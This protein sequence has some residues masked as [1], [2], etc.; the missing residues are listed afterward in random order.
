MKTERRH[1]LQTN[2]LADAL[3]RATESAKPYAKVAL[4][5]VVAVAVIAVAVWYLNQQAE[6]TRAE[7]WDRYF[8][9]QSSNDPEA[10]QAVA[11]QFRGTSAGHWALLQLADQHLRTGASAL[12]SDRAEA[13]EELRKARQ[14]YDEVINQPGASEVAQQ[15][16]THGLARTLEALNELDL[17]R[18][19]YEQLASRWPDGPYREEAQRRARDLE[20]RSTKEFYDWFAMQDPSPPPE[21]RPFFENQEGGLGLDLP[22]QPPTGVDF[23][24][25]PFDDFASPPT[26][27]T[28]QSDPPDEPAAADEAP[29]ETESEP[30]ADAETPAEPA[31]GDAAPSDDAAGAES[32]A[33]ASDDE[34]VET[35]D[36]P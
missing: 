8:A 21:D 24:T 13:N 15:R 10:M 20:R 18:Q 35:P 9:A 36:A 6:A 33:A 1:E 27:P 28:P 30:A 26:E 23:G 19:T 31:A 25:S 3:G 5:V 11:D 22:D 12:F 16:A 2:Q 7:G 17:A 32:N 14:Y 29:A 34:S 4:G